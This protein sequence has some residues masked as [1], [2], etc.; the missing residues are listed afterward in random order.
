MGELPKYLVELKA[1]EIE[2]KRLLELNEQ[3]ANSEHNQNIERRTM[4]KSSEE[5]QM[6]LIDELNRLPMTSSTLRVKNRRIEIEKE[7]RELD[8]LIKELSRVKFSSK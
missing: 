1:K 4:L 6:V 2:K 3:N 8:N 7:L 5:H